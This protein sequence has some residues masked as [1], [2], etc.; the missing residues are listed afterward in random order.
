MRDCSKILI[1]HGGGGGLS[2]QLIK[3]LFLPAFE[4]PVSKKL[5]DA[6]C[7]PLQGKRIAFSTDSYV[8][9]P[10]FFLGGDIGKLAVCGTINDLAMMGAEPLY[11]S[12][13][14]IIEEGFPLDTL[15]RVINSM[16]EIA[17]ETGVLIVTGDTKVVE[18]G[19]LD[20]IFINTAGIGYIDGD[21]N[22]SGS[23]AKVGDVV[24]L[25]GTIGDHGIAV[26]SQRDG[27]KFESRLKSD[28]APLNKLVSKMVEKSKNI[29][30]LRDPTRGGI[31]TT[32]NEISL[33]SGIEIL[34]KEKDIPIRDE[35]RA[36]CEI[37]GLDPLNLP[38][39][40]KLIAFVSGEDAHL[41]LQAM[42]EDPLGK[43]ATI[44][45][46][47]SG[48]T[49]SRVLLETIIGGTRIVNLPEGDLLPRIC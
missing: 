28:C 8:V 32:L 15:K 41:V 18:K 46:E 5:D 49:Q 21:L 29:H 27:F 35:V 11:I 16:K 2:Y 22:I 19:S 33:Q 44:I 26:L 23:N 30:V 40:G 12:A 39:E 10:L 13:A 34:I 37:L 48:N 36:A 4:N 7:L 6:A 25:S 24:I 31:A 17:K 47:V 43:D 14:F 1:A 45:G 20:Q 3:E 9:K 42:R 38:S